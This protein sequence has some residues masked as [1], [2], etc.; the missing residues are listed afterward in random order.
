MKFSLFG[1]GQIAKYHKQA[2]KEFGGTIIGIYDPKYNDNIIFPKFFEAD[3]IVICSPSNFHLEHTKLILSKG[4]GSKII[5]EK[6]ACLP[7]QYLIDNDDIN[8]VLQLRY[9]NLPDKAEKVYVKMVRNKEYFQSWKGDPKNT[10]GL[11]Y[12]L[13][14]HYIDLANILGADFEGIVVSEGKQERRIDDFDIMS[15]DMQSLYNKMYQAI[16]N[17]DGVK[18]KDIMYLHFIMNEFSRKYGYGKNGL[19]KLITIPSEL[20]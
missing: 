19:N 4:W 5:V 7:W 3:Y 15:I 14:I 10:G 11:F 8:V 6:P 12:N 13:F 17:G 9:L 1:D 18:P 16:I 20:L 2:I